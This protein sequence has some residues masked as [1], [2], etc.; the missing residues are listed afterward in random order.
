V[1]TGFRPAPAAPGVAAERHRVGAGGRLPVGYRHSTR[2]CGFRA[3]D[4]GRGEILRIGIESLE[5][6]PSPSPSAVLEVDNGRSDFGLRPHFR[7]RR[8]A[9]GT[10]VRVAPRSKMADPR[11]RPK[12]Q[13]SDD[14]ST[15]AGNR[16]IFERTISTCRS[17]ADLMA[18]RAFRC[19]QP[20]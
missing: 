3:G 12:Y 8:A 11:W 9:T 15:T 5:F 20:F 14:N 2:P 6:S 7:N 17:S 4:S 1:K 13:F 19:G 18:P 10:L 16:Q